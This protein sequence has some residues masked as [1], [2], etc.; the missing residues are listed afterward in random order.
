MTE[1]RRPAP[2][3][4]A[5]GLDTVVF[6][7]GNVL[8]GWDPYLP[9]A[10]TM[11]R[12]DWEVFAAAIDFPRLNLAADAGTSVADVVAA[13]AEVDAGHGRSLAR[14]YERFADSLTGPVPGSAEIVE[15]LRG[16]GVRLLGL[17]NWSAETFH[18]A[19]VAAPAITRLE[20]VLVSGEV[21]LAKPDPAIFLLLAERFGVD[22]AQA[23]FVD[24]SPANVAAA[25]SV[26]FTAR[27]FTGAERFREDLT[28]LG[29]LPHAT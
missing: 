28:V 3:L 9:L 10:G 29:L 6:D 25:E 27:H 13:A 2:D 16:A 5:A 19:P 4:Q 14:Y 24:D 26:G 7:L 1:P 23:V 12:E 11:S 18:H 17:T 8:V 20:A 21:G 22:P 15:D